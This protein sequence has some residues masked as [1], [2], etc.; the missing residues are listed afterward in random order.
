[1]PRGFSG[2]TAQRFIHKTNEAIKQASEAHNK[3]PFGDT[4]DSRRLTKDS[5]HNPLGYGYPSSGFRYSNPNSGHGYPNQNSSHYS[6]YTNQEA[7]ISGAYGSTSRETSRRKIDLPRLQEPINQKPPFEPEDANPLTDRHKTGV[8]NRSNVVVEKVVYDDAMK[9]LEEA[10]YKAGEEIYKMCNTI[11][12]I[13]RTIYVVSETNPRL[14]A[15]IGRLRDCLPQFRELT[16]EVNIFTR[17]FVDEI[18]HIDRAPDYFK[19]VMSDEGAEYIIGTT[20]NAVNKQVEN[21]ESTARSY[22]QGAE[23][24]RNQANNFRSQASRLETRI[25]TL[26]VRKK[27]LEE[28]EMAE[29]AAGM[30]NP[31]GAVNPF[32]ISN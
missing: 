9:R 32:R 23:N 10:D 18:G 1:M 29:R 5:P 8:G 22:K 30:I 24:L 13:C 15:L 20:K 31:I 2:A 17:K 11:D 12:E 7:S 28:R 6:N 4:Y 14:Q 16:E 21:M 25:D 26:D 27:T 3:P 19:V